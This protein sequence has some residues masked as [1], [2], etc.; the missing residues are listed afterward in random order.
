MAHSL[1]QMRVALWLHHDCSVGAIQRGQ[2]TDDSNDFHAIVPEIVFTSSII[3]FYFKCKIWHMR[4]IVAEPR[5]KK[6]ESLI[7]LCNNTQSSLA[8]ISSGRRMKA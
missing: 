5:Q 2:S 1:N 4:Q 7:E 8:S 6:R 3:C